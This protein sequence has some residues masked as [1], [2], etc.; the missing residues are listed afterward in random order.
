MENESYLRVLERDG[1]RYR[2][3]SAG[4]AKAMFEGTE[5]QRTHLW[6]LHHRRNIVVIDG[7]FFWDE[8]PIA[9]IP[10]NTLQPGTKITIKAEGKIVCD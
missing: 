2:E 1:R 7:D 8:G 6:D 3:L 10:A 5:K 9:R 4:E